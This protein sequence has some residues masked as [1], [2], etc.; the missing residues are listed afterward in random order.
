MVAEIVGNY[1]DDD[2]VSQHFLS[3]DYFRL[4]SLK[5]IVMVYEKQEMHILLREVRTF[6]FEEKR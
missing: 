1:N 3:N 2:A 4:N 6:R 5:L